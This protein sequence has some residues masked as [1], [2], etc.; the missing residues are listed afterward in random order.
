MS[1]TWYRSVDRRFS[2]LIS[3]GSM[4][5][6][7]DDSDDIQTTDI[8]LYPGQDL[9]GVIRHQQYGFTSRPGSGAE[10][11][12]I[13]EDGSRELPYI[14]SADHP[15]MRPK[16][17]DYESCLWTKFGSHVWLKDDGSL[18]VKAEKFKM[19]VSSEAVIESPKFAVK[20]DTDELVALLYEA[21]QAIKMAVDG[22]TAVGGSPM[23]FSA[24]APISVAITPL[25]PRLNAFIV[26]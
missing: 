5:K 9:G 20:G 17:E 15:S 12:L 14:I 25:L 10:V 7:I 23:P 16:I 2:N 8:T 24:L 4:T 3:R 11:V 18:D 21:L 13:C 19:S 26:S 6:P 1:A 22:I